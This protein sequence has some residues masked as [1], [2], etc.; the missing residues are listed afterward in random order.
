MNIPKLKCSQVFESQNHLFTCQKAFVRRFG[1]QPEAVGEL[2]DVSCWLPCLTED[3]VSY[4]CKGEINYNIFLL[5][6]T[7]ELLKTG[8]IDYMDSLQ[9]ITQEPTGC[10]FPTCWPAFSTTI[11]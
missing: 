5:S 10:S 4:P 11:L 8:E 1:K 2:F 3:A 7:F 6:Q 9:I